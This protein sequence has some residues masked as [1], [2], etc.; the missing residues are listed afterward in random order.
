MPQAHTQADSVAAPAADAGDDLQALKGN[1]SLTVAGRDLVVREYEFYEGLEVAH[2][3]TALIAAMHAAC[4][5]GQLRYDRI[6]RLFG[7]HR[8]VVVPLIAQSTDVEVDWVMALPSADKEQLTSVWFGVNASFFVQ[9]VVMDMI[10]AAQAAAMSSAGRTSSRDLP[11]PASA[12]SIS[13]A[14]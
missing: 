4:S 11:S 8:D 13:S 5:D 1:S 3:A 10:G 14:G 6:R 7:A 12:P 2:R 9:E